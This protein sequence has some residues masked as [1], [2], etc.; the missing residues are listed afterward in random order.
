MTEDERLG[1]A[2]LDNR[3][4]VPLVACR[5]LQGMF[6]TEQ[7]RLAS[8]QKQWDQL[9]RAHRE[10]SKSIPAFGPKSIS[11]NRVART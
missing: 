9:D 6:F 8:L 10:A 4:L 11:P 2:P 5:L 7:A 1:V 3:D